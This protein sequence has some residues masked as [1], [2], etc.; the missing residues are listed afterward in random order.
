MSTQNFK[1]YQ[2]TILYVITI[3]SYVKFGITTNWENRSKAYQ[4]EL[5]GLTYRFIKQINFNHRWQA[6]LIEQV[7]KWRLRRWVAYGRHEWIELPI[8]PVLDCINETI[9][10]LSKEFSKHQ[11]I[12]KCGNERWDYYRQISEYY[13][14]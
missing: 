12:H 8:Q 13:F 4:K 5:D 2:E 3:N 11:F 9:G 1:W 6:E 7:V 10:E 14:K